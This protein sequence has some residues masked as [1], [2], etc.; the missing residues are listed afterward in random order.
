MSKQSILFIALV[1][2][3]PIVF[4]KDV[5]GAVAIEEATRVETRDDARKEFAAR[6]FNLYIPSFT[7][8]DGGFS[9]FLDRV[10]EDPQLELVFTVFKLLTTGSI[11]PR[12]TIV[13][14][15]DNFLIG[16]GWVNIDAEASLNEI[17]KFLDPATAGESIQKALLVKE[18]APLGIIYSYLHI[19]FPD[20]ERFFARAKRSPL[21]MQA[22]EYARLTGVY[23]FPASTASSVI[24][25]SRFVVID[26]RAS[27][28]DIT[29]FMCGKDMA[30]CKLP[31]F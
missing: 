14:V 17:R 6:N 23:V 26:A 28:K 27:E 13:Y 7:G 20:F 8:K 16:T 21:I 5:Y 25:G 18:A 15:S 9:A 31:R 24:T 19:S 22:I 30:G 2:L 12:G 29:E 1:L 3:G 4:S 10:A 11:L